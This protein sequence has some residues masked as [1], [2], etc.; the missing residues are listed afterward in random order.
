MRE[1]SFRAWDK[2]TKRM[3]SWNQILNN[4]IEGRNVVSRIYDPLNNDKLLIPMQFTG[5][6]DKNGKKIF[7]GDIVKQGSMPYKYTI[8]WDDNG[9]WRFEPGGYLY[10]QNDYEVIGNIYEDPG[11]I[12]G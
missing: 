11:L 3:I 2:A 5:L 6:L 8:E 12:G 4:L 10:E 1:I 9:A 7:E